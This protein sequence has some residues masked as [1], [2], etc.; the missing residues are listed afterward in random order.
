MRAG[1]Y[2]RRI[3]YTW[4]NTPGKIVAYRIKSSRDT[5]RQYQLHTI[6]HI[7]FLFFIR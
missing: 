5:L 6:G 4:P 7:Y 1:D 2:E 3:N